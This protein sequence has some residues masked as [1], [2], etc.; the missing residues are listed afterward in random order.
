LSIQYG[1]LFCALTAVIY[2]AIVLRKPKY[3]V[4]D[5]FSKPETVKQVSI[6]LYLDAAAPAVLLGQAIGR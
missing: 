2:F 4:R 6:L 5:V 1:V 3:M